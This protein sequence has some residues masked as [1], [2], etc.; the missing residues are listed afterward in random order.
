MAHDHGGR[1][2]VLSPDEAFAVLGNATR[3]EVLRALGAADHPLSFSELYDRV[4]YDA[5]GNF[6]YHL[7]R[8]GDHFVRQVEEG[9]A[10]T[11][12]GKRVVKSVLSGAVT[13]HPVMPPTH[14]RGWDCPYCGAPAVVG[15]DH[16]R[17]WTA[18]PECA[19][20]YGPSLAPGG[21][22]APPD[23]GY[24]G[25]A[26]LPPA[27]LEDRTPREVGETAASWGHLEFVTLASGVCTR[28]GAR[29]DRSVTVCEQHDVEGPG[30]C[31]GCDC[32]HAVHLHSTCTN[33]IHEEVTP[34]ALGRLVA[35]TPL[36]TFLATHGVNPVAPTDLSRFYRTLLDY[37]EE[38][39][40]TDPFEAR[41]TFTLDGDTLTLS[42]GPELTVSEVV[43]SD[44]RERS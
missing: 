29:L 25:H 11:Q 22:L 21:S 42:V 20:T 16:E 1:D 24:I 30:L 14:P 41:F 31:E 7:D 8:L 34:F 37:E 6:S 23:H 36:L 44:A 18:C 19:G 40:S 32:R 9:Y 4:D 10:L 26:R 17:L 39:E 13:E 28:C 15:Y 35:T 27:A 12:A 2:E 33:C 38:V 3:V 43:R 5:R